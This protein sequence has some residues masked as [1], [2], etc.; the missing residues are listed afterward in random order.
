MEPRTCQ[1]GQPSPGGGSASL[2]TA[3][4]FG[5]PV[6]SMRGFLSG[7]NDSPL[8]N[9]LVGAVTGGL[10]P[11][12]VQAR[13]E[14]SGHSGSASGAESATQTG[15]PAPWCGRTASCL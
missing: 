15:G 8:A 11:E 7:V 5:L 10:S 2:C 1:K 6:P 14:G 13:L 3:F 12:A 9:G 4:A